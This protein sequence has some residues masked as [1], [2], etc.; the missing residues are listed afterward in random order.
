MKFR[1]LDTQSRK[2]KFERQDEPRLILASITV[3]IIGVILY[4]IPIT[5]TIGSMT[6]CIILI[7]IITMRNYLYAHQKTS[8]EIRSKD[9]YYSLIV[10]LFLIL[11]PYILLIY[12]F[13]IEWLYKLNIA[14]NTN[15]AKIITLLLFIIMAAVISFANMYFPWKLRQEELQEEDINKAKILYTRLNSWFIN[16]NLIKE[17]GIPSLEELRPKDHNYTEHVALLRKDIYEL[18]NV[19]DFIAFS[20]F[21]DVT[22]GETYKTKYIRRNINLVYALVMLFAALGSLLKF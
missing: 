6:A 13:N 14:E 21:L 10:W 2:S 4:F 11:V 5:K 19:I 3:I 12:L 20:L 18:K 8:D 17:Q 22:K 7:F 15:N 16:L 1:E 9:T